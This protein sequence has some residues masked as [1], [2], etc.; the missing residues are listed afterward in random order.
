[1][2]SRCPSNTHLALHVVQSHGFE[3]FCGNV[4]ARL[5]FECRLQAASSLLTPLAIKCAIPFFT[6]TSTH[7]ILYEGIEA[8]HRMRRAR[9]VSASF[10]ARLRVV[11]IDAV[12]GSGR[13]NQRGRG[14]VLIIK[15]TYGSPCGGNISDHSIT[16]DRP[17]TPFILC[18]TKSFCR[19]PCLPA[20]SGENAAL[21]GTSTKILRASPSSPLSWIA[22]K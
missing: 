16:L 22:T 9:A 10:S 19:T 11:E 1:L 7:G 13:R 5:N 17:V 6:V 12:V 3:L 8:T 20:V 2:G 15:N 18:A 4:S 21:Y 14:L